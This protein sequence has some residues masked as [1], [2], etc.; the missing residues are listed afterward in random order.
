MKF[1]V[2]AG[3]VIHDTRIVKIND[4]PVEQT[5]SYYEG[6]SVDFDEATATAHL[7]KLEP[8]DK[9]AREFTT[10][11]HVPIPAPA[12]QGIDPALLSQLIAQAVAAAVAGMQSVAPPAG[13]PGA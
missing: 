1:Q 7:H 9:A 3:F 11:R 10:A 13:K 2:R 6:D 8:Q 12:S 4:K 5:N